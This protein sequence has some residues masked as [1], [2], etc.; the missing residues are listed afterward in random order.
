LAVGPVHLDDLY[1]VA[2]QVARQAGTVG[3]GA[4]DAHTGNRTERAHPRQQLSIP[5]CVGLERFDVQKAAD[6]IQRRG[7]MNFQVRV[8][9]ARHRAGAFYDGHRHPFFR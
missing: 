6:G 8:N 3:T 5:G 2:V 4:L 9:S 7:D 1:P